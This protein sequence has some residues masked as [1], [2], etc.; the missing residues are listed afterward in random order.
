MQVYAGS[1]CHSI[2]LKSILS[3]V[4]LGS[5]PSQKLISISS[6]LPMKWF[7]IAATYQKLAY[8]D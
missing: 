5:Q 1:N 3:A 4:G 6:L 7:P 8:Q 2:K